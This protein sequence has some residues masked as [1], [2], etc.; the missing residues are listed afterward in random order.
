MKDSYNDIFKDV[1]RVLVVFAHPDDCEIVVG[2]T[3]ARLTKDGKQVRLVV[4]TNGGKGVKG[5]TGISEADFGKARSVEQIK[6]GLALGIPEDQNFNLGIGD[7][8]VE[9]NLETIGKIV[10]HIRDF[11]PDLIIT[12][13]PSDEIITFSPTSTWVN[14]RDHRNTG[15]NALD[16]AYPYSRDNNFFPEQLKGNVTRHEVHKL[17][18]SDSY[19]KPYVVS[20]DTKDY[21][22]EKRNGLKEHKSAINP[23]DIEGY[24]SEME[25]PDGYFELL[26]YITIY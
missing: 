22:E 3:I 11:K 8:E 23:E 21:L 19:T 25:Q 12:H 6:G 2:S 24:I 5:K 20:F 13:N 4:T 16:A 17:L 26:G 10:Y 14:H 1:E 9:H 15:L 18:F 7:G